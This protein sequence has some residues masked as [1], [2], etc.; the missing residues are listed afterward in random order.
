MKKLKEVGIY[1]E[2]ADLAAE[3]INQK[4]TEEK[5]DKWWSSEKVQQVR[6]E[7]CKQ[8]A[9]SSDLEYKQWEGQIS[10]WL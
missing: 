7:Y 10:E 2:N 5:L 8:Y 3:F 6:N 1:Y 4:L 9:N